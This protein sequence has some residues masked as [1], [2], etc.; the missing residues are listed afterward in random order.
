MV[1]PPTRREG[2]T[3][4]ARKTD[5][6]PF[7]VRGTP[8][9]YRDIWEVDDCAIIEAQVAERE[10]VLVAVRESAAKVRRDKRVTETG[11]P[12]NK[13]EQGDE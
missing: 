12:W 8:A 1:L 3:M 13:N 2:T 6:E 9:G 10:R 11:P 5:P 4:V 7:P